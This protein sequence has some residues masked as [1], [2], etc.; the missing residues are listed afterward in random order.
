MNGRRTIILTVGT[1]V[2]LLVIFATASLFHPHYFVKSFLSTKPVQAILEPTHTHDTGLLHPWEPLPT[3]LIT[4]LE[5]G[6]LVPGWAFDSRRD[7]R[8]FGLRGAQCESAFP[9]YYKE[10]GRAVEFQQT[11]GNVTEEE[12]DISWRKEGEIIRL[13]IYDHQLYVVDAKWADHG[14][15]VPRALALLSS[16]NRAIDSYPDP[17]PNIEFSVG[18]G[19]W[20]GTD[21]KSRPLWVL[22]R[23][24]DEE[25][26]WVMPDFGYWSWPLDVI[27]AY[28]Q[29]RSDITENEPDWSDKINKAVWRG[30]T[31]TNDLRKLLVEVS[32]G[33]KWSDVKEISWENSTHMAI[34]MDALSI[35]M[36][37]HCNYKYVIHTEGHTYSGRGKYL[38]NCASVNIVHKPDWIEPH[39][40][41]MKSNGPDQNIVEVSRDFGDLNSK[42]TQLISDEG[43]AQR[44]ANNSI[45]LFRDRYLTPAAQAC[46]WRK[47]FHGWASVSFEPELYRPVK[48]EKTGRTRRRTRGIPFETFTSDLM[49]RPQPARKAGV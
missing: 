43:E 27:G 7:E 22:T 48:D 40:H 32:E 8:N 33:K 25:D 23:R 45:H 29:V 1:C 34:G 15:D 6:D 35:S 41:L 39:T 18:L 17:L 11:R 31:G 3:S 28:S 26:K 30:A 13:M 2:P 44:I 12:V 47:L 9:D 4:P 24:F 5:D 16:I 14:F 19:D 46:Y 21:S 42:M 37:E 10:I 20:P 36:S 49:F 38:L